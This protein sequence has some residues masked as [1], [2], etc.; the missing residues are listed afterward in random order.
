MTGYRRTLIHR[1]YWVGDHKTQ[2]H[3][4]WIN[5]TQ[6]TLMK[7]HTYWIGDQWTVTLTQRKVMDW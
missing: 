4:Y 6:R 2:I 1:G 3:R 7:M 5:D